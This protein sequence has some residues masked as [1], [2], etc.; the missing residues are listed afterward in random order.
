MPIFTKNRLAR[1]VC[2]MTDGI[3]SDDLSSSGTV[4][5]GLKKDAPKVPPIGEKVG[6]LTADTMRKKESL[7]KSPSSFPGNKEIGSVE[8][9]V[10]G[11]AQKV[12]SVK[13][14]V[15]FRVKA[16]DIKNIN[17][18]LNSVRLGQSRPS[19]LSS[20]STP[21][22]LIRI[23][24][25][26]DRKELSAQERLQQP[27]GNNRD[28]VYINERRQ[29]V[30]HKSRDTEENRKYIQ[31]TSGPTEIIPV[32]DEEHEAVSEEL[33]VYFAEIVQAEKEEEEHRSLGDTHKS[34]TKK[35]VQ[36]ADEGMGDDGE[37]RAT[38]ADSQP[39]EELLER[40]PDAFSETELEEEADKE[41]F[42]K[43]LEI[44]EQRERE[45]LRKSAR[46]EEALEEFVA[47]KQLAEEVEKRKLDNPQRP[48]KT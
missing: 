47:K 22:P 16:N 11:A 4:Q 31:E 23:I 12:V 30:I 25:L 20:R 42:K 41:A 13:K 48:H 7:R 8:G 21:P 37:R 46:K 27:K 28:F 10:S 40:S 39:Q 3:K 34:S 9:A 19:Q 36:V 26:Q 35:L 18:F 32:D 15:L 14:S 24:S 44:A 33:E 5:H 45:V 1:R 2:F 29:T 38:F 6:K 17:N 43:D